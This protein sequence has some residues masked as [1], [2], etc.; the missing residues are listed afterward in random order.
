MII[1]NVTKNKI[2]TREAKHAISFYDRLVGLIDRKN[3]RFL[4]INTH[5]GIHTF[6]LKS[7]ID[8]VVL[9]E[10]NE[11]VKMGKKISPYNF[12]FYNPKYS[13]IIEMPQNSINKLDI[14]MNDKIKFE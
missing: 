4:I 9:N 3:P 14:S 2:I 7:P 8:L 6:F 5:F 10:K 1:R 13:K 11:V 12:F